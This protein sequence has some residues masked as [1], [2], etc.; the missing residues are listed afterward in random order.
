MK[1]FGQ[2]LKNEFD[3]KLLQKDEHHCD[4][5][6]FIYLNNGR[7]INVFLTRVSSSQK[8]FESKNPYLSNTD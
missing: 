8:T 5:L 4:G 3:E 1:L 6:F 7:Y 2:Q